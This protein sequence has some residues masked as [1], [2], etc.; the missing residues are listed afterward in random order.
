MLSK[1]NNQMDATAS[2]V[3]LAPWL[4]G[5]M[6]ASDKRT[7]SQSDRRLT[8]LSHAIPTREERAA[9]SSSSTHAM[10]VFY[11]LTDTK[12]LIFAHVASARHNWKRKSERAG[13][14]NG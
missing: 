1:G 11:S 3:S 13:G 14:A 4:A 7:A 2:K 5:Y 9:A 10:S 12:G 6:R 8:P